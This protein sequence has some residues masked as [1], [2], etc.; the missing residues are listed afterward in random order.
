MILNIKVKII[1]KRS[2]EIW[3]RRCNLILWILDI[4]VRGAGASR[5][6]CDIYLLSGVSV[7]P[8]VTAIFYTLHLRSM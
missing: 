6:P 8:Y 4:G 7:V 3:Y 1:I 2:K 5:L